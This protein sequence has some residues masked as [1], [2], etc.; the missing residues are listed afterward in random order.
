VDSRPIGAGFGEIN[1]KWHL[2][3]KSEKSGVLPTTLVEFPNT[4]LK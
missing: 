4:L 2:F 1:A 3:E